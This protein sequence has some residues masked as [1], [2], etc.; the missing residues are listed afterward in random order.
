MKKWRVFNVS[1]KTPDKISAK[2]EVLLSKLDEENWDVTNVN[3]PFP[4]AIVEGATE[5]GF[6]QTK[7]VKNVV[8]TTFCAFVT[9]KK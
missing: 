5:E 7:T 4:M 3:G 9:A 8:L 6:L 1:A 2:L